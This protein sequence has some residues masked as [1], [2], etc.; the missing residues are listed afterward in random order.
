VFD[1]QPPFHQKT[2][3]WDEFRDCAKG[4]QVGNAFWQ[5]PLLS[6]LDHGQWQ[7]QRLAEFLGEEWLRPK[8]EAI[9]LVNIQKYNKSKVKYLFSTLDSSIRKKGINFIM[10]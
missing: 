10:G 3:T 6:R 8:C 4:R 1:V 5:V 2:R 7:Q 9:T